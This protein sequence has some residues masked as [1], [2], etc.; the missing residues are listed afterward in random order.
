LLC[1]DMEDFNLDE[2]IEE[3]AEDAARE[4]ERDVPVKEKRDGEDTKS[5]KHN[6]YLRLPRAA[7]EVIL[8]NYLKDDAPNV[9]WLSGVVGDKLSAVVVDEEVRALNLKWCAEKVWGGWNNGTI[10]SNAISLNRATLYAAHVEAVP[11]TRDGATYSVIN[12]CRYD[13][14]PFLP[15]DN[16]QLL[17]CNMF[18]IGSRGI[19]PR[20]SPSNLINVFT[21]TKTFWGASYAT[22]I[23]AKV[24]ASD[25]P[26][27]PNALAMGYWLG[28]NMNQII[29]K[30][31]LIDPTIAFQIEPL[32]GATS[33]FA[34][35]VLT[36]WSAMFSGFAHDFYGNV[37]AS[38]ALAGTGFTGFYGELND[39]SLWLASPSIL[40]VK[41]RVESV[42]K[43]EYIE[44]VN[45][46]KWPTNMLVYNPTPAQLNLALVA[47]LKQVKALAI[48]LTNVLSSAPQVKA[49]SRNF[50]RVNLD[51]YC[52]D[53]PLLVITAGN[54][55]TGLFGTGLKKKLALIEKAF[56]AGFLRLYKERAKGVCY[57]GFSI[58]PDAG[59]SAAKVK[60]L[61][62]P[63]VFRIPCVCHKYVSMGDAELKKMVP[64]ARLADVEIDGVRIAGDD[65][66]G[67]IANYPRCSPKALCDVNQL[68]DIYM[69]LDADDNYAGVINI[70]QYLVDKSR[71]VEVEIT[72]ETPDGT[73][74][75]ISGG[76]AP[77]AA[78]KAPGPAPEAP[79]A[80]GPAP[81][82]PKPATPPPASPKPPAA[83]SPK[84]SPYATPKVYTPKTPAS[85]VR[86]ASPGYV[87][88]D[89][90]YD[91][92]AAVI[93]DDIDGEAMDE[94][95]AMDI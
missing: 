66:G 7:V 87:P 39:L 94:H 33:I 77:G 4:G 17:A 82:A 84:P 16:P 80:P 52:A 10:C 95:K 65:K 13:S 3:Y 53:P 93:E 62:E 35:K 46:S 89:D 29:D 91:P 26:K 73:T 74:I 5:A 78:P 20:P 9:E 86:P 83:A 44:Y 63:K 47:N 71:V 85:P 2:I 45:T 72:D 68:L 41:N 1:L 56:V 54:E 81:E 23:I 49:F 8:K 38:R 25:A 79:K 43:H 12:K 64:T 55:E 40:K 6:V 11:V 28:K 90:R 58:I 59:Y 42:I 69:S 30:S 27:I 31:K 92:E 75:D 34:G 36:G 19:E 76:K 51:V 60:V 48:P 18:R 21:K 37:S 67:I 70:A 14:V 57:N 50:A 24:L 32:P 15:G 22:P 61:T 88:P